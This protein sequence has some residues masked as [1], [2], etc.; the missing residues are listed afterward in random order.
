ML[1]DFVLN[2]HKKIDETSEKE[3]KGVSYIA[4]LIEQEPEKFER[5]FNPEGK[6]PQQNFPEKVYNFVKETIKGL[7]EEYTRPFGV[8]IS[9]FIPGQ[10]LLNSAVLLGW[11]E[12][13]C[14]GISEKQNPNK[15]LPHV[16]VPTELGVQIIND[17]RK[18]LGYISTKEH[19]EK[20]KK[21][22]EELTNSCV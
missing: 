21:F 15:V 5:I 8:T 4:G 11:G 14:V 19:M 20:N 1:E 22:V 18:S 16:M 13:K 3:K 10:K 2:E 17:Y 7:D 12:Y 9:Y 6:I